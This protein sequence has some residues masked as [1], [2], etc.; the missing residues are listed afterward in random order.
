MQDDSTLTV[1][2]AVALAAGTNRTAAEGRVRLVR[3]TPTG[4]TELP[5][6]LKDMQQGKVQDIA[7]QHDDILW[8]PFSYGKNLVVS[9]TSIVGAAG[10]AAIYRF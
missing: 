3:R 1:L 6:P 5:V 7:L 9:G 2:Q 10:S 8:V 4:V